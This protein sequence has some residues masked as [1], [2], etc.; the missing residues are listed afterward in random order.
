MDAYCALELPPRP[1]T[2]AITR[3]VLGQLLADCWGPDGRDDD[4]AV[5]VTEACTNVLRHVGTQ[6]PYRVTIR[7]DDERCL[8]EV[9]DCGDGFDPASVA[10]PDTYGRRGL[11]VMRALVDEVRIEPVRP[12]GT[13][14]TM[15]RKRE[16]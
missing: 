8:V 13:K 15:V 14:V 5:A 11:L 6:E 3:Q 10:A 9:V 4:L 16:R 7:V 1:W 2:L 12:R